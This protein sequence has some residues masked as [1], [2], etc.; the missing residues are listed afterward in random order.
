M[1]EQDPSHQSFLYQAAGK[2]DGRRAV[3]SVR[4]M[5]QAKFR[6]Y[7]DCLAED[8]HTGNGGDG[9]MQDVLDPTIDTLNTGPDVK[10]STPGV[11]ARFRALGL[12]DLFDAV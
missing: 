2:I 3:D 4:D 7:K 12:F 8:K 5:F 11:M 1:N 6:I 10:K 9:E